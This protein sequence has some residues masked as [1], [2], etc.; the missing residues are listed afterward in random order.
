M[1][2]NRTL[3]TYRSDD[4]DMIEFDDIQ[5]SDSHIEKEKGV[6]EDHVVQVLEKAQLA[7]ELALQKEPV[8]N[9]QDQ[10]KQLEGNGQLKIPKEPKETE[11]SGKVEEIKNQM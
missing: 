7:K 2:R 1:Q 8:V 11:E 5:K 6:L 3:E 9:Q 4:F 10:S